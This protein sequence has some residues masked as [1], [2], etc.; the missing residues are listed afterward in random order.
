[1][2]KRQKNIFHCYSFQHFGQTLE[3]VR[4][5]KKVGKCL[6]TVGMQLCLG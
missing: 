1:M 6:T 2:N 4:Y 3:I 5:C